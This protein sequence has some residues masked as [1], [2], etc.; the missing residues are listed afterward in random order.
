VLADQGTL[1][2]HLDLLTTFDDFNRVVDLDGHYRLEAR[3]QAPD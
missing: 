2:N 1:R 3:Y